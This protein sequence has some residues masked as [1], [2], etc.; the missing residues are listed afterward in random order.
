[1]LTLYRVIYAKLKTVQSLIKSYICFSSKINNRSTGRV[2]GGDSLKGQAHAPPPSQAPTQI[3]TE[4]NAEP[5]FIFF[6]LLLLMV[7]END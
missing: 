4:K 1:M 5:T 7:V 6:P 3:K 2:S